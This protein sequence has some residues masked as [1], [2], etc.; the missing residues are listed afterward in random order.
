MKRTKVIILI[1]LCAIFFILGTL[2]SNYLNSDHEYKKTSKYENIT[3]NTYTD[4]DQKNYNLYLEDLK[5]IPKDL[6]KNCDNI[7][8]TNENLNK[9][10]NLNIN[11]KVVAIS[12]GKDIYVSTEYYSNDV[13]IHEMYHVYDYSN[14]WI[15]KTEEFLKLYDEY[16]NDFEVSPGNKENAYEFFATYGENFTLRNE[17]LEETD[18][19]AFFRNLNIQP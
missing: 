8:F 1:L 19:Y 18:L 11:T 16:K 13:L 4:F 14:N 3:L 7:Y 10:F 2:T 6:I 12:Y 5:N 15:S 9:K 17:E